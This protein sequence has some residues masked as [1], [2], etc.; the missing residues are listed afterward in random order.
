MGFCT[1]CGTKLPDKAV[2][3]QDCGH[4]VNHSV[5]P[6]CGKEIDGAAGFCNHCGK[7]LHES[8]EVKPVQDFPSHGEENA[9]VSEPPKSKA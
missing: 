5:C 2:F 7:P 8:Q 4:K 3:C 1:N 9:T 6:F